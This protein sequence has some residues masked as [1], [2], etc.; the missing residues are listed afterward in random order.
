MTASDSRPPHSDSM[1][2]TAPR[3][4][5]TK[6]ALST[7]R[8]SAGPKPM[9]NSAYMTTMLDRPILMPGI[10]PSSG[11]MVDSTKESAMASANS[12]PESATWRVF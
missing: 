4:S 11:V 10:R 5:S 1:P 6:K 8:V 3:V 12:R 2:A 9:K 7:A